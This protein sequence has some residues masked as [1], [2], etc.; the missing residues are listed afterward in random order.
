MVKRL[1]DKMAADP[2]NGEGWLL[3]ARTYGE[4][5]M[6]RE[7]ADAYAKAAALL[8]AD[9]SLLADWAAVSVA[10][11]GGKWDDPSR[12]ILKRAIAT[13]PKHMKTLAL[14]GVEAFERADRGKAIEYWERLKKVAP[15]DSPDAKMA[16]ANLA[17]ARAGEGGK[18]GKGAA[19]SEGAAK[20]SPAKKSA[21]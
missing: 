17:E 14:A 6:P 19:G 3:L 10:T 16:D 13:D 21:P 20:S 7:S 12:D 15:P 11:N 8:P 9:A 18:G 5:Q 4:L 1:A 2:K